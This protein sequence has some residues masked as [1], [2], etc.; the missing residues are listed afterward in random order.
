MNK[1]EGRKLFKLHVYIIYTGAEFLSHKK[2]ALY[3]V[4]KNSHSMMFKEVFSV[5]GENRQRS[6]HILRE[7]KSYYFNV[8]SGGN[9][10]EYRV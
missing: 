3:F 9:Y 10:I 5:C 2:H 6:E 4:T 8:I 7:Q 1:L